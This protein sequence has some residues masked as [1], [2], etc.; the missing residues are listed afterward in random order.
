MDRKMTKKPTKFGVFVIKMKLCRYLYG[1]CYMIRNFVE[2]VAISK[3]NLLKR[4]DPKNAHCIKPS[5]NLRTF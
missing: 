1:I 3:Q 2:V 4:Q 5:E